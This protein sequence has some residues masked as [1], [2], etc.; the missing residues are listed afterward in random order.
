MCNFTNT[1][2]SST[3]AEEQSNY[4][5]GDTYSQQVSF[6]GKTKKLPAGNYRVIDGELLPIFSGYTQNELRD[7]FNKIAKNE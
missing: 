1:F 7:K 6:F 5:T 4:F 3:T 2:F